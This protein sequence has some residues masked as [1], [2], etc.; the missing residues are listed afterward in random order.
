MILKVK[1][2][3]LISLILFSLVYFL[4]YF[5]I[6]QSRTEIWEKDGN[7]YVIFPDDKIYLYYFYR[8]VSYID[9]MITGMKFH[10]GQ[11]K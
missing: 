4:S 6:R 1:Q 2:T 3:V 10:I 8:P 9:G 7:A 11:H 5:W